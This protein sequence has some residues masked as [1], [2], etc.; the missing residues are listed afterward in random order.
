LIRQL[1]FFRERER[2]EG[3]KDSI[4][5]NTAHTTSSRKGHHDDSN[6]AVDDKFLTLYA[7]TCI[8]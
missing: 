1:V 7:F 5:S 8:T 6:A 2:K 3:K 4:A